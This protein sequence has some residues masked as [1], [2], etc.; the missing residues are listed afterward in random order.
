MK[1]D[2]IIHGPHS[3][4]LLHRIA[5]SYH[6]IA[7]KYQEFLGNIILVSYDADVSANKATIASTFKKTPVKLVEVHDV[8]NPGYY[9]MN[10]QIHTVNAGLNQIPD[11]NLVIKLRNDQSV[12]FNKV[13]AILE[14][15]NFFR[16]SPQKIL[17]TN[18]YTRRD[19]LYHPSDMFLVGF[20]ESL[21]LYYSY[22]YSTMTQLDFELH[23]RESLQKMDANKQV[24]AYAPES[25]LFRHYLKHRGWQFKDTQQDSLDSLRTYIV[26]VNSWDIDYLWEKARTPGMKPGSI[27]LPYY[28]KDCPPFKGGPIE[29]ASC[30]HRHQVHQTLPTPKDFFYI[31]LAR[32]LFVCYHFS[33]HVCTVKKWIRKLFETGLAQS[34]LALFQKGITYLL[35]LR[36]APRRKLQ[37]SQK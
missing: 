37:L 16:S 26:L 4:N 11:K 10:R 27:V 20:K 22:P 33:P 19:R 25:M 2:L 5:Q 15:Q 36:I 32:L 35:S 28:L 3:G 24:L 30:L 8:F 29:Q 17:T 12:N 7:P 13:L 31:L 34:F 23:V 9:N 14:K 1:I 18:C 6:H 21:S